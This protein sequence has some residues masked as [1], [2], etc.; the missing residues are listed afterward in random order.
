DLHLP[1]LCDVE[2]I[3]VLRRFLREGRISERRSAEALKSYL[4]LPVT[5]HGH[6]PLLAR[7]L[8]LRANFTAYDAMYVALGELLGAALLTTDRRLARA[9]RRHTSLEVLPATR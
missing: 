4:D 5:K 2:M 8:A 1:A 9:A 3:A 7:A 6:G